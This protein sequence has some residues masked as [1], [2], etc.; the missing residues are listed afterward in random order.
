MVCGHEP[1]TI[2]FELRF[3]IQ[4]GNR[5]EIMSATRLLFRA[6]ERRVRT[7]DHF[8]EAK[9]LE[10]PPYPVALRDEHITETETTIRI[11]TDHVREIFQR[12]IRVTLASNGETIFSVT[13]KRWSITWRREVQDASGL[14]L[15]DIRGS[16]SQKSKAWYCQLPGGQ[17]GPS[18]RHGEHVLEAEP[19]GWM[20]DAIDVRFDNIHPPAYAK[21]GGSSANSNVVLQVRGHRHKG[22]ILTDVICDQRHIATF[23]RFQLDNKAI[24]ED[25]F[26]V[27]EATV[28]PNVDLTLVRLVFH[29]HTVPGQR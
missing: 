22:R 14:P 4:S 8:T 28:A 17:P 15:V 20:S 25:W 10:V 9:E 7:D 6:L 16:W 19:L 5:L 11:T 18:G 1:D 3:L 24:N 27:L 13:P 2:L 29:S 12:N 26:Q 21:G 23:R